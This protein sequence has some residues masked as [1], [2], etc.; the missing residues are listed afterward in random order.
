[1]VIL[2]HGFA[3]D[4]R[5]LAYL[6]RH[7]A[8]H[9][10]STVALEHPGSS[11]E[12]LAR[13]TLDFNP[14]DVLPP[15]EFLDRPKDVSFVLNELERL[16]RNWSYL[17]NKF[18]TRQVI[19]IGHSLGGYTALALAGGELDLREL[20]SFCQRR[21]PLGRSPAD[22]LQCSAARLPYSKIELR[23]DRVVG[24]IALNPVVGK[25]FGETGLGRVQ[26]PTLILSSSQDRVTP[27]LDHQL[28]PFNL[29]PGDK[30]FVA[31]IGATHMSVTDSGN[32]ESIVAQNRVG[33]ELMGTEAEPVR[34]LVRGLS[35]AWINQF[36]DRA[37]IYRP[38]LSSAYVQSLS[39]PEVSLRLTRK[40]PATLNLWMEV[41]EKSNQPLVYQEQTEERSA[42]R[43]FED[44]LTQ[45]KRA[46]RPPQYCTAQ[47]KRIFTKVL[48]NEA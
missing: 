38:F 18:N 1:M 35:L 15:E 17:G 23:D 25:L 2:S 21:T 11:I 37:I 3:A 12:A 14:T 48:S 7:L 36:S 6:A 27:S 4:R 44:G 34:Q 45:M 20:R 31:A 30:Y 5:F 9:G 39:T 47:L 22:W 41:V 10:L 26:T 32:F 43:F 13:I 40:F 28:R 46:F 29:L 8:S 16:G 24:A 42:F 19:A 33:Q